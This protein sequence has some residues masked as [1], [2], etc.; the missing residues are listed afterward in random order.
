MTRK[1]VR[2]NCSCACLM[3]MDFTAAECGME[4]DRKQGRVA[5]PAEEEIKKHG[6]PMKQQVAGAAGKEVGNVEPQSDSK[7][8]KDGSE[9]A[10]DH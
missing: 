6:D 2:T 10:R 7:D 5:E 3:G 1:A 9:T 8:S 4:T